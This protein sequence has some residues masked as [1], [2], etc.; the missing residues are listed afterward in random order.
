MWTCLE[1]VLN[2]RQLAKVE[3]VESSR[4]NL[5]DPQTSMAHI[6]GLFHSQAVTADNLEELVVK[7]PISEDDFSQI[8]SFANLRVLRIDNLCTIFPP[9]PQDADDSVVTAEVAAKVASWRALRDSWTLPRLECLTLLGDAWRLVGGVQLRRGRGDLPSLCCLHTEWRDMSISAEYG[10]LAVGG[11][12][13][14][15]CSSC[16]YSSS[17]PFCSAWLHPFHTR[18]MEDALIREKNQLVIK[19]NELR[20]EVE[21]L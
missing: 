9:K 16:N 3:V 12:P 18:G 2:R 10:S 14:R 7:V 11:R 17:F 8:V 4:R 19:L 13:E 5:H 15:P 1:Y 20:H 6:L 21:N